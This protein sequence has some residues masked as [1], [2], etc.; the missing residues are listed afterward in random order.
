M[1]NISAY[2][3]KK[4]ISKM[5]KKI[6]I[7]KGPS[8][9]EGPGHDEIVGCKTWGGGGGAQGGGGGGGIAAATAVAAAGGGIGGTTGFGG[10]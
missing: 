9:D 2:E 6:N 10:V 8:S 7:L 4:I 3:K 5:I 1:L